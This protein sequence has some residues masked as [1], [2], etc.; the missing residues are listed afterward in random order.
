MTTTNKK[1]AFVT[2][3]SRG[4]GLGIAQALAA[5][6]WRLAINGMRTESDVRETLDALRRVRDDVARKSSRL[7]L[8]GPP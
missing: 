1:T 4:I 3:G 6:G 5:D 8:D 7:A 2:G